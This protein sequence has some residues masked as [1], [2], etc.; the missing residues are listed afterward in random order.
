MSNN[1]DR[2]R[3]SGSYKDTSYD[4]AVDHWHGGAYVVAEV[5]VEGLPSREDNDHSFETLEEAF[6]AAHALARHLIDL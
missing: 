3:A 6:E 5:N 1:L 2:Y 4:V